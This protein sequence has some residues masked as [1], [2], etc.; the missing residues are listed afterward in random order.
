[1]RSFFQ[2]N[3]VMS[4]SALSVAGTPKTVRLSVQESTD[5]QSSQKKPRVY[6][7][8]LASVVNI[9]IIVIREFLFCIIFITFIT[10]NAYDFTSSITTLQLSP[11][12]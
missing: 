10:Y 8:R 7:I 12:N 1:M 3:K 4:N 11:I 6:K 9:L 5:K 2:E